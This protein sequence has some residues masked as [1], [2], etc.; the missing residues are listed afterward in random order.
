MIQTTEHL[1]EA[2]I[3]LEGR[4]A[5]TQLRFH[6]SNFNNVSEAALLDGILLQGLPPRVVSLT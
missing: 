2:V 4:E 6:V 3:H 5:I 1:R